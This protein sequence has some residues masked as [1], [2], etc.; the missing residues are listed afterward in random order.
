MEFKLSVADTMCHAP[1]ILIES[2]W[3]LNDDTVSLFPDGA[4]DINRI[5]V[6]FK[7]STEFMICFVHFI[8]IELQ[9]NLNCDYRSL[10]TSFCTILIESQW[11]L[12]IKVNFDSRVALNINRI[13]VE[14]K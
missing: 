7:F 10:L 3:N 9:W 14:F 8:L 13:T 1:A 11:N 2:Q 12:N 6:E 5:T 4:L